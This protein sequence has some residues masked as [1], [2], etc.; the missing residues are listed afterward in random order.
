LPVLECSRCNELY[1][2]AHGSTELACD[3]CDG[4]VWR[5]FEDEVSFARVSGLKRNFQPGDH[6]ALLYTSPE[7]AA[8]FCVDFLR[9]GIERGERLVIAV[10][11]PFQDKVLAG[12]SA[13]ETDGAIVLDVGEVYGE[14]FDPV[15]TARD[16]ADLVRAQGSVRLLCG[17]GAE[18]VAAMDIDDWRRYERIAHELILDLNATALCIYDGRRLPI[19]YSPVAVETHPLISHGGGELH[20]NAD[21]QHAP[22]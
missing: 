2:S 15:G 4:Q 5:V 6:G 14:S 11:Q 13:S 10:P 19:A 18:Q 1:Y 17:P 21:F 16:Y 22:A 12:M 9:D 8:A 20:R 7:Q 3:G